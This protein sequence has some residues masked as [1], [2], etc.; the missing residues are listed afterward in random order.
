[1]RRNIDHHAWG[2]LRNEIVGKRTDGGNEEVSG[3]ETTAA[4]RP[5]ELAARAGVFRFTRNGGVKGEGRFTN[6][7]MMQ[8]V[9]EGWAGEIMLPSTNA[10]QSQIGSNGEGK[11]KRTWVEQKLQ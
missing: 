9:V 10:F 11:R 4:F 5:T 3:G 6:P 7:A 8:P 2:I 1:M